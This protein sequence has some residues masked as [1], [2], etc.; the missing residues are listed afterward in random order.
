M[1]QSVSSQ[2]LHVCWV[3]LNGLDPA[4]LVSRADNLQ[5]RR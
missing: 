3:A 4:T 2:T 1:M 5:E